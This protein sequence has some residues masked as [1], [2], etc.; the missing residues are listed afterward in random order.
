MKAANRLQG[1]RLLPGSPAINSGKR[2][3]N[4]GGK[5]FC[6]NPIIGIPDMGAFEF[7]EE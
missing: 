1:Y 7:Q 3:T 5:D 6:G 4:N 2:I